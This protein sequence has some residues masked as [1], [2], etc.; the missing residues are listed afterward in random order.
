MNPPTAI[1]F[2]LSVWELAHRWHGV[3]P[4]SE[5]HPPYKV[6]DTIRWLCYAIDTEA[7]PWVNYQWDDEQDAAVLNNVSTEMERADIKEDEDPEIK[8]Q[9][10]IKEIAE[11]LIKAPSRTIRPPQLLLDL[12]RRGLLTRELL[13]NTFVCDELLKEHCKNQ[14]VAFPT[15]WD[16]LPKMWADTAHKL[17]HTER[18]QRQNR[19]RMN[20]VISLAKE[21]WAKHPE[22]ERRNDIAALP[23]MKA[24]LD[25]IHVSKRTKLDW[26]SKADQR[27]AEKRPKGRRKKTVKPK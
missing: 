14:G 26:I 23:D 11:Q 24:L 22:A 15:F 6:L 10:I 19:S 17:V 5:G 7:L 4:A 9:R 20:E 18:K 21:L 12:E 1:S 2:E 16:E 3:D 25:S 8:A 27:P 13:S